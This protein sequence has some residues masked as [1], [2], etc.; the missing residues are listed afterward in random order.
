MESKGAIKKRRI[1]EFK[2][3]WL[4]ESIFK[5]WFAPHTSENK[6][7]CMACNKTISCR[8]TDLLNIHRRSNI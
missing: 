2:V 8:K 3:A 4:D 6:A 1:R 5:G 7:L